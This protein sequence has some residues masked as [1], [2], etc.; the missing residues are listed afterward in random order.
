MG[1]RVMHFVI[2]HEIIR[3]IPDLDRDA[4]LIG[5][6]APDAVSPKGGSHFFQGSHENYTRRIG[7]D[8][9]L[10][11]YSDDAHKNYILGYYSHL[12]GDDL[13]LTG[14]YIPW[15]KNRIKLDS[16]IQEKYHHDFHLLNGKL[17]EYYGICQK[18]LY[19]L[20]VSDHTAVELNEV[21][22][23][24]VKKFLPFLINDFN[25]CQA[26][27]E[28]PLEVFTFEQIIGYIETSVEHSVY[29][30][31]KVRGAVRSDN[32]K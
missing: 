10:E 14:F 15:L 13:W 31:E 20:E 2:A 4:F 6:I 28:Q 25:Y 17:A 12:I 29:H 32:K 27:I 30:I 3:K 8:A 24:D 19:S 22:I 23:S 9:F 11:K 16:S 26:V 7:Y 21:K 18:S 5:A 1:S